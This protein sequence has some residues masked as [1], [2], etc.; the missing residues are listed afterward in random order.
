MF[1][2]FF[3]PLG[4]QP[5]QPWMKLFK[6]HLRLFGKI[7]YYRYLKL[8]NTENYR[9]IKHILLFIQTYQGENIFFIHNENIP[10]ERVSSPDWAQDCESSQNIILTFLSSIIRIVEMHRVKFYT[11]SYK[12]PCVHLSGINERV[13]KNRNYITIWQLISRVQRNLAAKIC[14]CSA[15][16]WWIFF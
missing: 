7:I 11:Q 16:G 13:V 12:F 2:F 10:S 9:H 8:D 6:F 14:F 5:I 15:G 4:L 3:S 1:Q